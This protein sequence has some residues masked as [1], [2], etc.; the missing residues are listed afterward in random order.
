VLCF[1]LMEASGG[2]ASASTLADL[3]ASANELVVELTRRVHQV[4]YDLAAT[5]KRVSNRTAKQ[6]CFPPEVPVMSKCQFCIQPF[7]FPKVALTR[8][9]ALVYE[10]VRCNLAKLH[11]DFHLE[12][13]DRVCERVHD[14]GSGV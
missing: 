2:R 12:H 7:R 10:N 11:T 8:T 3:A 13:M 9:L 4:R 1:E 5:L 6:M 14:A